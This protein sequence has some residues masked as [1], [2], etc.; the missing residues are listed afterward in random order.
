M[1]LV[2]KAI[3]VQGESVDGTDTRA[4]AD[5]PDAVD[6][7][8]QTVNRAVLESVGLKAAMDKVL[9]DL[10]VFKVLDCKEIEVKLE[11][12]VVWV[13]SGRKVTMV[14]KVKK[15]NVGLSVRKVLQFKVL[16]ATLEL[17]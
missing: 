11:H 16:K 7:K 5:I 2:H 1:A 6:F 15:A 17:V 4:N 8:E 3:L 14:K 9:Q 13:A 12:K 10:K